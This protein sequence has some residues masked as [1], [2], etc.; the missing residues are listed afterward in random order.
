M[1]AGHLRKR[2]TLQHNTP[3]IGPTG[4]AVADWTN[5]ATVWASV[6]E[7]GCI[8]HEVAK[9]LIP[10]STWEIVIRYRNDMSA[11][12]RIL[13]TDKGITHTLNIYGTPT[14]DVKNRML[15]MTCHSTEAQ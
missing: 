4:Q 3:T 13:W 7:T 12:D 6:V 5:Y 14:P 1:I 8:E 15:T 2:I 10:V 9:K 11:L